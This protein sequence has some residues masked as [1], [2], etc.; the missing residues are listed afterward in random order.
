MNT[1]NQ[2]ICAHSTVVVILFTL[3]GL[4]LAGW[5]PPPSPALEAEHVA[6]I[7]TNNTQLR[8]GLA[9]MALVFPLFMGLAVAIAAQLRRIEGPSH[10]MSNLQ[11]LNAA[12]G[13]L[14]VQFPCLIWLAISYR[15]GLPNEIMQVLMTSVGLSS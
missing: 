9:I 10:V 13:V 11:L 14:A 8:I 12:I 6:G 1:R 7:F 2:L 3:L 4:V 5:I 15:G